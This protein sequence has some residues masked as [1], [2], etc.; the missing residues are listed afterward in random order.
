[1]DRQSQ[2]LRNTYTTL[3]S[4]VATTFSQTRDQTEKEVYAHLMKKIHKVEPKIL[5]L[6]AAENLDERQ[7][8]SSL[9]KKLRLELETLR[10]EYNHLLED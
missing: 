9:T 4:N 8:I 1:M 7:L 3:I 2:Q 6:E 10:V 5:K